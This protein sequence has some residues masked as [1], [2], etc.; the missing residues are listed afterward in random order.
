[1]EKEDKTKDTLFGINRTVVVL[2]LARLADS[3]GNSFLIVVLPLYIA[4]KAVTGDNFGLTTS[5]VTGIILALFGFVSGIAQ[6]FAGR[7]ADKFGKRKLFV[8]VGLALFALANSLYIVTDTYFGLFL[9]RGA[10]GIAA[11]FTITACVALVSEVSENRDR[12]KNMGLYNSLRLIG[13]G[14]GP[15]ISGVVI[16]NGPF[17]VP[18]IGQISGFVAAFAIA[19]LAPLISLAFVAIFVKD[20]EN[21]KASNKPLK[22][23]FKSEK[24]GYWLDPIFVLGIASL[25]MSFGFSILSPIE[26]ETNA[27]LSQGAI[28]FSVE[29]STMVGVL[30]ITQPI[31]GKLTDKYG[32]RSF[33]LIGL[34]CLAPV[35]LAQGLVVEPWQLIL[36]R[37][38]Q[39]ICAAMIFAPALALAGDLAE[40]GNTGSQLSILT[41][42]FGFGVS[43]GSLTSGYVVKFGYVIPFIIGTILA[44]IGAILVATQVP[45]TE[46]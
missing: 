4:S 12:G 24:K 40:K 8:V 26:T 9:V 37:G 41:M 11:A 34:I 44:I 15:L 16:E 42:A 1:M 46:R 45:K 2:G 10:Q 19:A 6:P 25:I 7:L 22:I 43:I 20:P 32:R 33:I 21:I 27:R 39:G 29:F 3:L 28:L 18:I 30:I 17:T 35:I 38:L 31:I 36:T 13:F 5:F 14:A 23:R